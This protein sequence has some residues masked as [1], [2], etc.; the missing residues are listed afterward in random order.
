[1]IHILLIKGSKRLC[2]QTF[3][4]HNKC[5]RLIE[6]LK[7]DDDNNNNNNDDFAFCLDLVFFRTYFHIQ[8]KIKSSVFDNYSNV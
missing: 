7:W 5:Y 2:L 4:K 6:T 3:P 1:M 8:N